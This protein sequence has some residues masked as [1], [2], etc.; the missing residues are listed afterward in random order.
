MRRTFRIIANDL[1]RRI[2]SPITVI[3]LLS[4]PLLMTALIGVIF[5]PKSGET[6]LPPIRVLV[7]DRDRGAASGLLLRVFDNERLKGMFRIVKVDPEEGVRLIGSGKA[8]ALLVIPDGFTRAL[9]KAEPVEL[10]FIKNPSEQFLPGIAE[11]MLNTVSVIVSGLVQIFASELQAVNQMMETDFRDIPIE[12]MIPFLECGKKKIDGLFSYLD[13]LLLKLKTIQKETLPE[14]G[15]ARNMNVFAVIMP[16][17]AVMF[18]LF[19]IE[20]FMRDLLIER[21]DRKLKR[22][23]FSPLRAVEVILA[24]VASGWIA[25]VLA[26]LVMFFFGSLVFSIEWGPLFPLLILVSLTSFWAASF[27]GLLA[28]LFRSRNQAS[29]FT[30]P[31]ILV[32]SIFGGSIVPV[33]V[34]PQGINWISRLTVN[35]WFIDG[36]ARIQNGMFPVMSVMVTGVSSALLFFAAVLFFQRRVAS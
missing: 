33:D 32:F 13:P 20:I 14:E 27:F 7:S 1:K 31:V 9:I 24:R 30:A 17:M 28:V 15:K 35:H 22:M 12:V 6:G 34:L 36:T 26:F 3:V 19:I 11:E 18:L 5:A 23:M 21:M 4:I 8:S 2:R 10:E 25:G 16:G 29:V